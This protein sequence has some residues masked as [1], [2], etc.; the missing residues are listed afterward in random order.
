MNNSTS[1]DTT[2]NATGDTLAD[3]INH[4]MSQIEEV[5]G[6]PSGVVLN[7]KDWRTLET[8]KDQSAGVGNYILG[9]PRVSAPRELWGVPVALTNAMRSGHFLVADFVA[10]A[11]LFDRMT[12]VIDIS[13][14]HASFF[15]ANMVAIRAEER[16]AL[17]CFDGNMLVYG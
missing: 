13:T 14:E 4:A 17:V 6:S 16:L 2:R 3:R 15:T 7:P 12:A 5:N 1:Y 9:G 10:A 8:V 11:A